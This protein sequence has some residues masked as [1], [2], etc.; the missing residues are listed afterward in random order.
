MQISQGRDRPILFAD[1][2]RA[3][4]RTWSGFARFVRVG[5]NGELGRDFGPSSKHNGLDQN[6]KDLKTG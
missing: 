5:T 4:V 1:I 6:D 2:L 3:R